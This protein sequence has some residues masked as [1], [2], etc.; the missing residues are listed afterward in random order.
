M[1]L[2]VAATASSLA[3]C[4]LQMWTVHVQLGGE[5]QA[6]VHRDIVVTAGYLMSHA[7]D[8][9]ES[10]ISVCLACFSLYSH[11]PVRLPATWFHCYWRGKEPDITSSSAPVLPEEDAEKKWQRNK[12]SY[13]TCWTDFLKLKLSAGL[14]PF[15]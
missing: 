6:I 8:K 1:M 12:Q 9:Q 13:F 3:F 4:N 10:V 7:E 11:L 14:L 2:P 5:L 15:R